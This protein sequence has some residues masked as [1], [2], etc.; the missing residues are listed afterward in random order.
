[1]WCLKAQ[2]M[3]VPYSEQQSERQF[4]SRSACK[5]HTQYTGGGRQCSPP[6]L[7]RGKA[8]RR[9]WSWRGSCWVCVAWQ[10]TYINTSLCAGDVNTKVTAWKTQ[11]RNLS[12]SLSLSPTQ[13]CLGL[14]WNT[15]SY[16]STKLLGKICQLEMWRIY[17][18]NSEITLLQKTTLNASLNLWLVINNFEYA[19]P[20]TLS[21]DEYQPALQ[22]CSFACLPT[23]APLEFYFS[24]Q[25]RQTHMRLEANLHKN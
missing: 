9:G 24:P 2:V 22:P 21:K 6:A 25:N 3:L 23:P 10:T 17:C 5:L 15:V 11:E 18:F 7:G 8:N 13:L 1:M 12:L 14:I 16:F 20:H 4:L 19:Y